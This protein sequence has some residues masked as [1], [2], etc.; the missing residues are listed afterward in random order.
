MVARTMLRMFFDSSRREAL[1]AQKT[2]K[3]RRGLS[4]KSLLSLKRASWPRMSL[5]VRGLPTKM[6][7]KACLRRD[8]V[9]TE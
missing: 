1:R 8:L 5:S 3:K 6:V 9:T 7:Y 2:R 4:G